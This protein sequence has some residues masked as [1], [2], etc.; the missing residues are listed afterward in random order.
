MACLATANGAPVAD[1]TSGG[2]ITS[3][4]VIVEISRALIGQLSFRVSEVGTYKIVIRSSVLTTSELDY[5]RMGG[6]VI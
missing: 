1:H 3:E 5:L 6:V 4:N 2:R